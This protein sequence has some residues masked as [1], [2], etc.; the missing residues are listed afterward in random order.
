MSI[1]KKWAF[2]VIMTIAVASMVFLAGC[3]GSNVKGKIWENEKFSVLVPDG[4]E[5]KDMEGGIQ[6][7]LLANNPFVMVIEITRNNVTEAEIKAELEEIVKSQNAS[8]IEEVTMLGVKFFKTTLITETLDQTVYTGV[9]NGE[10]VAILLGGK[11]HKNN[12]EMKA[13]LESIKFK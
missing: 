7:Q 2:I 11:D 8:P 3:G 4:W 1:K 13:M 6:I 10:K 12:E 9:R 5:T